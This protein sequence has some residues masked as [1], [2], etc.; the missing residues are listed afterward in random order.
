MKRLKVTVD[1]KA[2]DVIVEVTDEVPGAAAPIST[3]PAPAPIASVP[4]AAPAPV[5]TPAAT[6]TPGPGLPVTAT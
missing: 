3:P 1:G 4:V 2:Y 6:T 5:A